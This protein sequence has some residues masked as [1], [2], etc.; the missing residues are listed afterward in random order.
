L[1]IAV[2]IGLASPAMAQMPGGLLA[3]G[4][5]LAGCRAFVENAPTGD[6]MQ[7]GACAGAVSAVLDVSQ[8]LR[9]ACPPSD[10]GVIDAARVVIRFS[11]VRA[12][13]ASESFG[14]MALAA[15][16]DRWPC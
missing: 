16:S 1:T 9:R 7:M 10:V 2:L 13:R 6:M 12:S 11:D 3:T 5:L 8:T 14:P 4:S 15:L